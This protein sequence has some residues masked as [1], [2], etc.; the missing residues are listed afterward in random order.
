MSVIKELGVNCIVV[1]SCL[2]SYIEFV[3]GL[4]VIGFFGLF[5]CIVVDKWLCKG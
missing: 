4:L 1:V 3:C 5:W 2:F